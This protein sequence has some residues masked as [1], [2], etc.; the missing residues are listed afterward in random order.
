MAKAVLRILEV[1]ENNPFRRRKVMIAS[2]FSYTII[3]LDEAGIHFTWETDSTPTPC[4]GVGPSRDAANQCA[5]D[6]INHERAISK[7]ISGRRR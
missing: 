4:G 2:T 1:V 3:F 5:D 6:L 7:E